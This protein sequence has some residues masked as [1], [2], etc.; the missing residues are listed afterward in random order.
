MYTI[1][2]R[3]ISGIRVGVELLDRSIMEHNS[4]AL[5]IDLF[6]LRI[7]IIYTKRA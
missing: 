5:L 1:G 6:I 2:L 7:M 3:F 4:T